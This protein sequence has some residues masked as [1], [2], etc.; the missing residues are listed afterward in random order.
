MGA[1]ILLL[2]DKHCRGLSVAIIAVARN[3]IGLGHISRMV[4]LCNGLARTGLRPYLFAEGSAARS[5]SHVVPTIA[6]GG[7]GRRH[8]YSLRELEERVNSTASL[9]KPASVIEDTHPLGLTLNPRIRRFLLVRPLTFRA[10]QELAQSAACAYEKIFI[11]DRPGSPTWPYDP[12][13]TR[14]IC[15]WDKW[16]S[17]GPIYRR[18][19]KAE[20]SEV[21]R[22]YRW[23]PGTRLCVFS[24]GGGG[25][26]AGADDASSFLAGA[27]EVADKILSIDKNAQMVWVRGPL[28][29]TNRDISGPFRVVDS[30]E[31][32]HA[33]FAAA[34]LACI[35]PGFNSTWECIAGSTPIIPI[36]GTSHQEPVKERLA[37]L[38]EFGALVTNVEEEWLRGKRARQAS[39][40]HRRARSP[41]P[42]NDV[43][44]IRRALMF[45]DDSK[46]PAGARTPALARQTAF[47]THSRRRLLLDA[48][49]RRSLAECRVFIRIDDVVTLDNELKGIL[50]ILRQQGFQPSLQVIP[51]LCD[52]DAKD[53]DSATSSSVEITIGQHGYCHVSRH[54]LDKCEFS[55]N[56][57]LLEEVLD[58]SRGRQSLVQRFGEYFDGG[59]S[60]PFD[61]MP[62]WLGGAWEQMGGDFVS[63]IR[64]LPQSGKVRVVTASV[65]VWSWAENSRKTWSRISRD[66]TSSIT[67]LGYAGVVLHPQHLR[68]AAD[69]QWLAQFLEELIC[70]GAIPTRM[71]SIAT[72]QAT[73]ALSAF[74][75][76]YGALI[77]SM[78]PL[79]Q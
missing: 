12:S 78:R 68:T 76:Q 10:M 67:R 24:L 55:M 17:I 30:E 59:I 40:P 77:T 74:S 26:H 60:M 54:W 71:S 2:D 66:I 56:E 29:A 32:M 25:E 47:S 39:L 33:L 22:R 21:R 28:M 5:I 19:T 45:E 27:R 6:I 57:P 41:Y 62:V 79:R 69:F 42:G 35:R 37:R 75:R 44:I 52:F 15:D 36:L 53:I 16:L 18:A 8:S 14:E 1:P 70:S 31:S 58:L 46:T 48:I 11:A 65:D 13:Q 51:Y 50:G 4:T 43:S 20:I 63:V 34:D 73:C 49:S 38:D 23:S 64:N 3:G 72:F 9:S 7:P 61:A